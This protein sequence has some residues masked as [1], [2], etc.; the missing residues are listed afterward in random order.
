M[1]VS[2][3]FTQWILYLPVDVPSSVSKSGI[4][5]LSRLRSLAYASKLNICALWRGVSIYTYPGGTHSILELG[6]LSL[7]PGGA[8]GI[9]GP[10]GT[11]SGGGTPV[12]LR[13]KRVCGV[14]AVP[15]WQQRQP[16]ILFSWT[17]AGCH[18]IAAVIFLCPEISTPCC[19]AS[20]TSARGFLSWCW[21]PTIVEGKN[22][23]LA[24]LPIFKTRH[25]SN[26]SSCTQPP[27][28][29]IVADMLK[30]YEKLVPSK[31]DIQLLPQPYTT[32]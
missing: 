10:S 23:P 20:R 31:S 19:F 29:A 16:F 8:G 27:Y 6:T 1:N 25:M 28:L 2:C 5:S 15:L 13:L 9:P 11:S 3:I 22:S 7:S 30:T 17:I 12:P 21:V 18:F 14:F 32:L 4:E 24:I 26:C